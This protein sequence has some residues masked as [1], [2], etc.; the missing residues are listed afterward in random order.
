VRHRAL[1]IAA[2]GYAI[3]TPLAVHWLYGYL[4]AGVGAVVRLLVVAP[5]PDHQGVSRRFKALLSR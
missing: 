4:R 1:T 2:P 3:T 5:A